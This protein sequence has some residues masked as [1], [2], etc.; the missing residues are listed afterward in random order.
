MTLTQAAKARRTRLEAIVGSQH[1]LE[2]IAKDIILH[3][4]QR[5]EVF[6]GKAMIVTI[7]RKIA[8]D[9]FNEIIKIRPAWESY[10]L[11]KGAIK[12]VMTSSSADGP[13]MEKHHTTKTQRRILSE[14]FKDPKDSLMIVIVCDMWLT[15]F[16]APCL[17]TLYMDKPMKGHNLM[18]AIAR[19]NRIYLDKPG[20]LIVD[21]LG[22]AS[23]LKKALAFYSESGGK[24]D[25][26]EQ[27]EEAVNI[28]LSK[29][30]VIE[31]LFKGF[32]YNRYFHAD[33]SLKLSI[34]L[35]AEEHIL[36]LENGKERF[37][38]EVTALSKAFAL[39]IPHDDAMNV[40][41]KVA[42]FQAIKARIQKFE[43]TGT[44]K[45]DEEIE[46]AIKQVIDKAIVSDKI[47]DI[48]DAAGIK[49]PNIS[50]LS[51]DFMEEIKNMKH[52]SVALELLKKLLNEEIKARS[53]RN[54]VQC[55]KLFEMLEMAIR[56]YQNN[57][58]SAAEVITELINLSKEIRDADKRGEAMKMS[59]DELAFYDALAQN[60]SARNIMGDDKLREL[61]I[62]LVDRIRKN[63]TI[64]WN[65]K[66]N[67]HARMKV[68][69]KR[70]LRQYGY[71]PDKQSI[72]TETVLEQA[73]MFADF[74]NETEIKK[75]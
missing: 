44:G 12:V 4:E 57:I 58:L 14:R 8:V 9:L 5:Q 60:E 43:F 16:D 17:N 46:S 24:G 56:K 67:V 52:K 63:T 54:M 42:F 10:E 69:V 1:R 15:G 68:M 22:I 2:N 19:V 47:V 37:I 11:D 48:F 26:T 59:F 40:K 30:E 6:E 64:D 73:K 62:V 28:M 51:D 45:S 29:L 50:I 23:D 71:P 34:I 61:A 25:P 27:Q 36:N 35:E 70:L 65:I 32:D 31:Q 41:E 20:G 49:K 66:E 21:Y 7:S 39:A 53:K 33:T 3:F 72:A 75:V 55:R 18:Q 38:K 13:E 74:W